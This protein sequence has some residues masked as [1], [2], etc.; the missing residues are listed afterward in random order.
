MQFPNC[1]A[2]KDLDDA[3]LKLQ[4]AISNQPEPL[5]EKYAHILSWQGA[6]ERLFE[7]SRMLK[8]DLEEAEKRGDGLA[9]RKSATFHTESS[10]NSLYLKKLFGGKLLGK[11]KAD[12]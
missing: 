5:M 2:Y 9:R 7:A 3:V 1:L 10:R 11:A 6:T 12:E 8:T 4:Y